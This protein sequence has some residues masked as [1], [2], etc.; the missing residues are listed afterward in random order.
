MQATTLEEGVSSSAGIEGWLNFTPDKNIPRGGETAKPWN[1]DRCEPAKPCAVGLHGLWERRS[2]LAAIDIPQWEK[3]TLTVDSGASDTVVPPS[4]ARFVE[5]LSSSKVGTEYEVANGGVV[6][7]LGEKRCEIRTSGDTQNTFLMSFQVVEV[8]KPLLAVSK[9]IEAG[10]QVVFGKD[11]HIL[12]S[13]GD[14]VPI[15]LS[16]GTYE[17]DVW[18][19]NPSFSRLSGK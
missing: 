4:V 5:L 15:R 1:F 6:V 19:K 7:N 12:L 16:G 8:H 3:V 13:C 2:L 17:V 11:S 10:H 14:K 18:I 9:L